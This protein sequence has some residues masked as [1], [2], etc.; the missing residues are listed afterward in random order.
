[1]KPFRVYTPEIAPRGLL[2]HPTRRMCVAL[3]VST[4]PRPDGHARCSCGWS[5]GLTEFDTHKQFYRKIK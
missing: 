3:Y 1:M 2:K 4:H 5:G